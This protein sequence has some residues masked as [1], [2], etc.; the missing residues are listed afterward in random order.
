MRKISLIIPVMLGLLLFMAMPSDVAF[1]DI[2][3]PIHVDA[4]ET[5]MVLK[6]TTT[7]FDLAASGDAGRTNATGA[8][9]PTC[10]G[11][12]T[13]LVMSK[14][15]TAATVG[16]ARWDTS[17]IPDTALITSA[18]LVG[19]L[20]NI[21]DT[22]GRNLNGQY[23]ASSNWPIDCGDHVDEVGTDA[24]AIDITG[25]ASPLTLLTPT[26]IS[27]TGFTGFRFGISGAAPTGNNRVD[28]NTFSLPSPIQL[29]VTYD[30]MVVT[31]VNN[32]P[33]A[34]NGSKSF[35][36]TGDVL[37]G[38]T[39]IRLEKASETN[40][41]CT[42]VV[43][44]TDETVGFN[45][46]MTSAAD[47][48]W[49]IVATKSAGSATGVGILDVQALSISNS[50]PTS[51]PPAGVG[52][53]I[54]NGEGMD[55]GVQITLTKTAQPTIACTSEIIVIVLTQVTTDCD[56]TG[57]AEGFWNV[58]ATNTSA[59]TATFTNG[60]TVTSTLVLQAV[61]V[62]SGEHT[63][64]LTG[65]Q[66]ALFLY[67]DEELINSTHYQWALNF[68]GTTGDVDM[69]SP[70]VL[71]NVWAGGGTVE[72]WINPRGDGEGTFGHI[73]SKTDV[74]GGDG[75]AINVAFNI[76]GVMV[77]QFYHPF[78]TGGIWQTLFTTVPVNQFAHVAVSYNSD[79]TANDPLI[80]INGT[81]RPVKELVI[82]AGIKED[83]AAYNLLIGNTPSD[84]VTFDGSIDDVRVWTDIRT[85]A[86]VL[87]NKGLKLVGTEAGLVGYWP[88]D[89]GTGATLDDDTTNSNDG[90]I[91]TANWVQTFNIDMAS[92][93]PVRTA[94][95]NA[96]AWEMFT[97]NAMPYVESVEFS[98]DGPQTLLYQITDLPGLTLIDQS[99]N[100]NDV[101]ARYPDTISSLA[102]GVGSIQVALPAVTEDA[103]GEVLGAVP[104]ITNFSE[105]PTSSSGGFF[106][107]DIMSDVAGTSG[108]PYQALASMV[109]LA[110]TITFGIAAAII[111]KEALPVGIAVV[112]GLIIFWQM[113]AL[114][115]WMPILFSIGPLIFF[116]VWKKAT[117]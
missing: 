84:N 54:L 7:V 86:E 9:P 21:A 29:S 95:T 89:I 101:T 43:V 59:G 69:G 111:F 42:S 19:P 34:A 83:D 91:T 78:T 52:A 47:G 88:M 76:N 36:V 93:G 2:V 16:M 96:N 12:G 60:L 80:Y 99:G 85:P 97:N 112:L 114:P 107:F 55:T 62:D 33:V 51:A 74:S 102:V 81:S 3:D 27:K 108:I 44:L 17:S 117:P 98:I 14:N 31:S 48:L 6:S 46:V 11:T 40:I 49:N 68:N 53:F 5:A 64:K 25:I 63:L 73:I 103:V 15:T 77:V 4:S 38:V 28:M 110:I 30:E 116:L 61:G 35:V 105:T 20:T 22:D 90:T 100:G 71:D 58:V 23:Y 1:L 72:A 106:L 67:L 115:G 13:G 113:G 70:A 10:I 92:D 37:T 18:T 50:S 45:C 75:W 66:L 82:P 26:N 57:V 8:Y 39:A 24:F 109:A 65:D 94:L 104:E 79:S 41:N 32:T 87:A 56:L